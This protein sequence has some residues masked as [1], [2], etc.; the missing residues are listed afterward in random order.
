LGIWVVPDGSQTLNGV[1]LNLRVADSGGNAVDLTGATVFNP[2]GAGTTRWFLDADVEGVGTPVVGADLITNM[3]GVTTTGTG[4]TGEGAGMDDLNSNTDP[5]F[6]GGTSAYLFATVDY[7]FFDVGA[8][9]ELFLQ[10]GSAGIA[11]T[12]GLV[13]SV[14]FGELDAD[15]SSSILAERNVD[16]LGDGQDIA[17]A[18][19]AAVPSGCTIN[20]DYDDSG[21]VAQGDLDLVLLNWGDT[22][23]PNPNPGVWVCDAVFPTAPLISQDE[24]DGVLLNWGNTAA[25]AGA[26]ASAI[27]E[28]GTVGLL[29]VGLVGFGLARR[30]KN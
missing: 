10:I 25:S 5:G 23:P 28:P 14:I 24:L 9:A 13:A 6:D 19:A 7:N 21:Q 4:A 17:D 11:D 29:L 20:G 22:V 18:T 16:Q 30:K 15:L 2:A 8:T 1:D 26:S 12:S 27:P 3:I